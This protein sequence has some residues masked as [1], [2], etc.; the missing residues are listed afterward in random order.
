MLIPEATGDAV[1]KGLNFSVSR[2]DLGSWLCYSRAVVTLGKLL[3][4]LA[5]VK[6]FPILREQANNSIYPQK[7]VKLHAIS[8]VLGLFIKYIQPMVVTYL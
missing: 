3:N 4:I 2:H 1:V 8:S 6:S 7:D 5:E